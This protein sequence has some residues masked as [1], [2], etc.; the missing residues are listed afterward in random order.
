[1]FA[2]SPAPMSVSKERA[3]S[4]VIR[5]MAGERRLTP[6]FRFIPKADLNAEGGEVQRRARS[7]LMHR[8]KMRIKMDRPRLYGFVAIGRSS[9]GARAKVRKY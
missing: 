5:A 2:D 1:M 8:R 6:H 9:E 4:G 3:C 7:G